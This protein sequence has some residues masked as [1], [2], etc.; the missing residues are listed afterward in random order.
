MKAEYTFATGK[1][2]V[3][4]TKILDSTDIERMVDAPN[5][6]S[7]FKVLYDTDYADNLLEVAPE[8]YRLALSDDYQQLYQL[9]KH[10]VKDDKLLKLL[11]LDRDFVNIKLLFKAKIF[12]VDVTEL[13]KKNC[14]YDPATLAKYINAEKVDESYY[15]EI[16]KNIRKL[17]D[18]TKAKI[19]STTSPSDIDTEI[20]KAYFAL[21]IKIAKGLKS[22]FIKNYVNIL[23]NNANLLTVLRSQRLKL[24]PMSLENKLIPGGSIKINKLMFAQAA[25]NPRTFPLLI[26][27][28]YGS[29]ITE[30]YETFRQTNELNKIEKELE[31]F[32]TRYLALA[33]MITYGPEVV[34]AYYHA[35][36]V[37]IN[38]IRIIMT[39]KINHINSQEIKKTL[40][41]PY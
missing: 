27:E 18:E 39:G 35:K 17:L 31:D 29:R 5:L 13:L 23:I 12:N 28:T 40:R 15:L 22:K 19:N 37:A 38:N 16:D 30:A 36:K 20:T 2:R 6:A 10:L 1:I 7:A 4:E 14:I 3:L 25:T 34:L 26:K 32:K 24:S 21:M 33:K 8:N 41:Q 9:V 11:F